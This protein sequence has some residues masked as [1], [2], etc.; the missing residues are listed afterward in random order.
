M[1][2]IERVFFGPAAALQITGPV[3]DDVGSIYQFQVD[4]SE[5]LWVQKLSGFS[6]KDIHFL[7]RFVEV[8]GHSDF[9]A[10]PVERMDQFLLTFRSLLKFVNS[11]EDGFGLEDMGE[12]LELIRELRRLIG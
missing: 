10:V 6:E 1:K 11:L 12:A 5:S 2:Q 3:V 9:P 8:L 7:I 4:G